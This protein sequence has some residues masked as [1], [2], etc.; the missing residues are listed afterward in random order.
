MRQAPVLYIGGYLS[1]E[2]EFMGVT[3]RTGISLASA[4]DIYQWVA[5]R[6]PSIILCL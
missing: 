2:G 1:G 4:N 5:P 3:A 6:S